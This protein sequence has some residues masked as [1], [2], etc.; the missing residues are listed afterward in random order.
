MIQTVE[1]YAFW[2][3]DTWQESFWRG[4]AGRFPVVAAGKCKKRIK[5]RGD[6]AKECTE[7]KTV[8]WAVATPL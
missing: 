7:E 8:F 2:D 1:K 5:I 4:F 6:G 3:A